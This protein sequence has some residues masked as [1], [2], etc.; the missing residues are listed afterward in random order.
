MSIDV[1]ALTSPYLSFHEIERNWHR[2]MD[3]RVDGTCNTVF[4]IKANSISVCTMDF[5]L[6]HFSR[7]PGIFLAFTN[8]K[9]IK[10][11]KVI[12]IE[13]HWLSQ[14]H[15]IA[16]I[17][18]ILIVNC[19]QVHWSWLDFF[20]I[21]ICRIGWKK[22]EQYWFVNFI[23]LWCS[24]FDCFCRWQNRTFSHFHWCQPVF[25]SFNRIPWDFSL[26]W[27]RFSFIFLVSCALC[28]CALPSCVPSY[29]L[30]IHK[31]L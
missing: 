23:S 13:S 16:N 30:N 12:S 28:E 27:H 22:R 3:R 19:T 14:F 15:L 29:A 21:V 26:K 11:F 25:L 9:K 2:W 4:E 18:G 6:K 31:Y 10:Y 8:D 5:L 17:S 24:I 20:V 7:E 1:D